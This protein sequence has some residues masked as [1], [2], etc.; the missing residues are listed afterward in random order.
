M[1]ICNKKL[2]KACF[3]HDGAYFHGKDLAKELLQTRFY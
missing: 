1:H 3:D 2:D